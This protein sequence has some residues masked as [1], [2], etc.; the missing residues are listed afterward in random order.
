MT[1]L[2]PPASLVLGVYPNVRGFGWIA[3]EGPLSPYDWGLVYVA[4]EKNARCLRRLER[5]FDRLSP[6]VLVVEAVPGAPR[7]SGRV[8]ALQRAMLAAAQ[9]RGVETARLS[10]DEIRAHFSAA[11][12]RTRQEI[13]DAVARQLPALGHRLPRRRLAWNPEDRRMAL[14]HAAALVLTHYHNGA[15]ALLDDLR[16]AA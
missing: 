11:G 15:T 12:V 3:F 9:A 5:L 13:A 2:T 6:E 14:F 4:R 10:R 1:R 16:N 8:I 7:R